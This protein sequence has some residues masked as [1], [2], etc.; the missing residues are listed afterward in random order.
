[1]LTSKSNTRLS[2]SLFPII[3]TITILTTTTP[4]PPNTPPPNLIPHLPLTTPSR[5]NDFYRPLPSSNNFIFSRLIGTIF[6]D[7]GAQQGYAGGE[8]VGPG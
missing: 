6:V 2:P 5:E 7:R 1:M 8:L 4:N 3:V